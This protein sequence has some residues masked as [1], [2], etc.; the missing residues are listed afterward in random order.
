MERRAPLLLL[1]LVATLGCAAFP[2]KRSPKLARPRVAPE[3]SGTP[4]IHLIVHDCT[5]SPKKTTKSLERARRKFPHLTAATE[6]SVN[7]DYTVE[8]SVGHNKFESGINELAYYSFLVIP[9][10]D[11]QEVTVSAIITN[12]DGSVLGTVQSVGR[13]KQV[14]QMHLL[15]ALPVALPLSS[16]VE[17]KMWANT[18]RDVFIQATNVVEEDQRATAGIRLPDARSQ[19]EGVYRN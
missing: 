14:V 17:R 9:A 10:I 4:T 12:S 5:S 18:F 15:W 16:H 6:H 1:L 13:I 8:L 3:L 19:G 2:A 11:T 7:P